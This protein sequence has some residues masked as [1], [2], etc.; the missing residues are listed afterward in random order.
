MKRKPSGNDKARQGGQRYSTLSHQTQTRPVKRIEDAL[1]CC[2]EATGSSD[3]GINRRCPPQSGINR[4]HEK[5]PDPMTR[6]FANVRGDSARKHSRMRAMWCERMLSV[7][8]DP[9]GV[10]SQQVDIRIP[11]TK[12]HPL[13]LWPIPVAGAPA[14]SEH[15]QTELCG[16]EPVIFPVQSAGS[17]REA[18]I[19][20]GPRLRHV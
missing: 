13:D 14:G 18:P 5:L 1:W 16:L 15:S 2:A 17:E 9:A 11:R 10:S 20:Q 8:R 3:S 12:A 7:V 19:R 4:V 6:V